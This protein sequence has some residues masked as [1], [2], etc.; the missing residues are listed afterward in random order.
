M[1][2]SPENG[3]LLY[4]LSASKYF[5]LKIHYRHLKD[6]KKCLRIWLK[7]EMKAFLRHCCKN[8][9]AS[10]KFNLYT[11][12][13]K[14]FIPSLWGCE[15]QNESK[16]FISIQKDK[17]WNWQ[18]RYSW[19]SCKG[20]PQVKFCCLSCYSNLSGVVQSN[21]NAVLNDCNQSLRDGCLEQ[22]P[23]Q[24]KQLVCKFQRGQ[25]CQGA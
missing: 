22:P 6:R 25:G 7:N 17:N 14:S 4:Q 21:F 5:K 11:V 13:V 23:K 3:K 18:L 19:S 16:Y 1:Q 9:K 15:I 24:G 20:L 2:H 10:L 8:S 12:C